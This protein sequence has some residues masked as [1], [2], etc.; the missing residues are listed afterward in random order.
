MLTLARRLG[1]ATWRVNQDIWDALKG[2]LVAVGEAL[3]GAAIGVGTL[4]WLLG[5]PAA[6]IYFLVTR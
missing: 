1:H 3:V 6:L 4:A 5:V 2:G